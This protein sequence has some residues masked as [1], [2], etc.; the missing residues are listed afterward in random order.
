MDHGNTRNQ[1]Q[2]L[3]EMAKKDAKYAF[4]YLLELICKR[5]L[6]DWNGE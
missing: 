3:F 2:A 5:F 1:I 4:L 6:T